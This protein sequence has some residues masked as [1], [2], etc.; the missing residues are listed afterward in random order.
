MFKIN[1]KIAI[2]IL[3]GILIPLQCYAK[4]YTALNNLVEKSMEMDKKTVTIKAEAIGEPMAR[5]DHTWIN[6][7]D[8][9]NSMGIWMKKQDAQKLKVFGGYKNKGD[10]I[11]V[12]GV[13]SRNCKEHGGDIDIHAEKVQVLEVGLNKNNSINFFRVKIALV[14]VVSTIILGLF[15]NRGK[16]H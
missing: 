12:T 7:N 14:L 13:Y 15:Y 6:V 2:F 16:I 1:R 10:I 5:G 9:T 3:V 11:E 8:G 4:E